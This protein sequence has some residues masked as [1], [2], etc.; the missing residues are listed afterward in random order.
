MKNLYFFTALMLFVI[1]STA[2]SSAEK[3]AL[4][5]QTALSFN[6]L[7]LIEPQAA[8]GIGFSKS[9][10]ARS[11]YFTELSYI[12]KAPFYRG[13]SPITGGYRWLLQ[14]RYRLMSAS[15]WWYFAA[16]E[17]RLKGYGFTGSDVFLNR[18]SNDTLYWYPYRANATSIGG[19]LLLGTMFNL[20][21]KG[22]W[23]MEMTAGMGAKQKIVN[24]KNLPDG[25]KLYSDIDPPQRDNAWVPE[26]NAEEALPYFPM[27]IRLR[28]RIY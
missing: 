8:A 26:L 28:Y 21:K 6:P 19:A 7:A 18:L 27:A 4:Q 15:R 24:Y 11:G 25:Y 14:Y 9:L 17:F 2:Q 10:T 16:A 13:P 5:K 12:F 1:V 22:R 20:G 3:R 23:Q